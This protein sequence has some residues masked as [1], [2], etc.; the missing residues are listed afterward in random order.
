LTLYI[1]YSIICNRLDEIN[2]WWR[3]CGWNIWMLTRMLL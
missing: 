1:R 3:P 2:Y